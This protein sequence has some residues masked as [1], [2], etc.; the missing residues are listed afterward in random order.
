MYDIY[1]ASIQYGDQVKILNGEHQLLVGSVGLV[2]SH[3][4]SDEG[5]IEVAGFYEDYLK[6]TVI[7][8]PLK[9]ENIEKI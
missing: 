5:D 3:T 9:S 2:I 6:N 8:N 1:G 7:M 4:A